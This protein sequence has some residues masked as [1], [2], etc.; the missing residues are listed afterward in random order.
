MQEVRTVLNIVSRG[1]G[2][3]DRKG[4]KTEYV[5][6]VEGEGRLPDNLDELKYW[7]D[8]NDDSS[9]LTQRERVDNPME[10]SLASF[11]SKTGRIINKVIGREKDERE[12]YSSEAK[13]AHSN[14]KSQGRA[15][16]VEGKHYKP[17]K[18]GLV[19]VKEEGGLVPV[20]TF[21]LIGGSINPPPAGSL[22][23]LFASSG[24]W[25][26]LPACFNYS[27]GNWNNYHDCGLVIVLFED[28]SA[29]HK[30]LFRQNEAK[31]HGAINGQEAL[32]AQALEKLWRALCSSNPIVASNVYLAY[33]IKDGDGNDREEVDQIRIG[34]YPTARKLCA[35]IRDGGL[36]KWQMK[37]PNGVGLDGRVRVVTVDSH[38]YLSEHGMDSIDELKTNRDEWDRVMREYDDA[39]ARERPAY[40]VKDQNGLLNRGQ[41]FLSIR[42]FTRTV[43]GDDQ[44]GNKDLQAEI[45]LKGLGMNRK[46]EWEDR[47]RALVEVAKWDN[48]CDGNRYTIGGRPFNK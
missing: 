5:L 13:I 11:I 47:N 2:R 38:Q 9:Q 25:T 6:C 18:T 23:E 46:N 17:P 27:R 34:V 21:G 40:Y 3:N 41:P 1:G 42:E 30:E 24:H 39:K 19:F 7:D 28:A 45:R 31:G 8:E 4:V 10:W 48:P 20:W 14:L 16:K 33:S 44:R 32:L 43:N 36:G 12:I 35:P 29:E 26:V 22:G 15:R 37:V